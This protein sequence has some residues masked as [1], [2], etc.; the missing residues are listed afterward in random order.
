MTFPARSVS[1]VS[2]SVTPFRG[3]MLLVRINALIQVQEESEGYRETEPWG[4]ILR[5]EQLIQ[6]EMKKLNIEDAD[7][8]QRA[9]EWQKIVKLETER[10]RL[11]EEKK[12]RHEQNI[13]EKKEARKTLKKG[14]FDLR[15][16]RTLVIALCKQK[17]K[18][19]EFLSWCKSKY[20]L[21]DIVQGF[22]TFRSEIEAWSEMFE[23]ANSLHANGLGKGDELSGVDVLESIINAAIREAAATTIGDKDY[24]EMKRNDVTKPILT[25]LMQ[26]HEYYQ[27]QII[28][29][30]A[31]KVIEGE[32]GIT[33]LN[34]E[35]AARLRLLAEEALAYLSDSYTKRN[36]KTVKKITEGQKREFCSGVEN[37]ILRLITDNSHEK[38][39]AESVLQEYIRYE[40][41]SRKL[42]YERLLK[43]AREKPPDKRGFWPFS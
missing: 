17:Q 1:V 23:K 12:Q 5:Y 43:K 27:L 15:E 3:L 22:P 33:K 32:E 28:H 18:W 11:E 24:D 25:A 9:Q 35:A 21:T 40:S 26:E 30:A 16:I 34:S 31:I 4:R 6:E 39:Y 36:G 14:N 42:E 8:I 2:N 37:D 29:A 19:F 38:I 10:A 7:E 20:D 13:A 41:P